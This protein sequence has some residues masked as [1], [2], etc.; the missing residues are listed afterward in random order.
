MH[1]L[2]GIQV[3]GE[4][5]GD[6]KLNDFYFSESVQDSPFF[7]EDA[8]KVYELLSFFP[9]V[10]TKGNALVPQG[11]NAKQI[12][13]LLE[14]VTQKGDLYA[15][16]E[17][18]LNR[19]R[20]EWSRRTEAMLANNKR[21][22]RFQRLWLIDFFNGLL[23]ETP[24]RQGSLTAAW[25][26]N[27]MIC[28]QQGYN[29]ELME[30]TALYPISATK[31]ISKKTVN[32]RKI[33]ISPILPGNERMSSLPVSATIFDLENPTNK[34]REITIV[35]MQDNLCGYN[36]LKDRHGVQDSSFIL[37]PN[38]KYQEAQYYGQVQS[39]GRNTIGIEFY[40]KKFQAESDCA[41]RMAI[42]AT[43]TPEPLRK[44]A[45]NQCSINKTPPLF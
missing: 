2:P 15:A 23:G 5:E 18:R 16:N 25:G 3:R 29:P 33:Q 31:Y 43:G 26:E 42:A 17:E 6:L 9:L 27:Q 7:V 38:A 39:N 22:Y 24:E 36:V 45:Q 20:I 32:I 12:A 30:Y 11:L 35:Q 34:V 41:G 8:A 14:N 10:D 4:K 40:T 37:Q 13:E 19:W 21:H 44:Q 28:E 1:F